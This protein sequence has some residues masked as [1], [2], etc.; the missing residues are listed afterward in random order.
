MLTAFMGWTLRQAEACLALLCISTD[1]STIGKAMQRLPES[2]LE[3]GIVLLNWRISRLLGRSGIYAA[4]STGIACDR[5]KVIRALRQVE[6]H[7]K[8][9]AWLNSAPA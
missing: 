3:R 7:V 8:L 2:Y 4:D 1:H 9:Y 5:S 6:E